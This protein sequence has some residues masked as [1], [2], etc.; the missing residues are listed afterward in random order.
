MPFRGRL[1]L[2]GR[3]SRVNGLSGIGNK[4]R[5]MEQEL[6]SVRNLAWNRAWQKRFGDGSVIGVDEV[7]TE[8]A[9]ILLSGIKRAGVS[10]VAVPRGIVFNGGEPVGVLV[11][12]V[13]LYMG[14]L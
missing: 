2:G 12:L 14:S 8:Q 7:L 13:H 6:Y 5:G 10:F 1:F 9:E 3:G 11:W 4:E